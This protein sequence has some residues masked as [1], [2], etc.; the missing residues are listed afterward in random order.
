MLYLCSIR[1]GYII[2]FLFWLLCQLCEFLTLC[3]D[4]PIEQY[5]IKLCSKFHCN[6]ATNT[7]VMQV[8]DFEQRCSP[9]PVA[10]ARVSAC[11]CEW[12]G[13]SSQFMGYVNH[14]AE[15]IVVSR[16]TAARI[17]C[18]LY[19]VL[20]MSIW[21]ISPSNPAVP[22]NLPPNFL[23]SFFLSSCLVLFTSSIH[24]FLTER[25][26]K[27]SRV[28]RVACFPARHEQN[29]WHKPHKIYTKRAKKNER[30]H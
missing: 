12:E 19:E 3:F 18:L 30:I 17:T 26:G 24:A 1:I 20:P 6:R 27:A 23:V 4:I 8:N 16:S 21:F 5:S 2:I 22:T 10:Y 29:T 25:K 14:F 9:A 28:G 11:T 7:T 13:N 15:G